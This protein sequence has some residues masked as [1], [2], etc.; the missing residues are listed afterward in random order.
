MKIE[1]DEARNR[2][3]APLA[4]GEEGYLAYERAGPDTLDFQHTVVPPEARGQGVGEA[5][6]TAA[7]DY[8]R[9]NGQRVIPTCG[10]VRGW[11]KEHP[12]ADDLIA[13]R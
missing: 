12:E 1:H 5:L 10:F 7:F 4:Q 11:M 9:Q 6:V 8:A 13:R 3:V 2:F